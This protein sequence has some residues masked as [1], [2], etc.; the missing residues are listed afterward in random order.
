MFIA[1]FMAK[2]CHV[3]GKALPCSWQ[4]LVMFMARPPCHVHGKAFHRSLQRLPGGRGRLVEAFRSLGRP[5]G[6][7]EAFR[8]LGRPLKAPGKHCFG[9]MMRHACFST[10]LSQGS[11]R[12]SCGEAGNTKQDAQ[13]VD[14][15]RAWA[16]GDN[17]IGHSCPKAA[18]LWTTTAVQ[19]TTTSWD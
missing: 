6:A 3:H 11:R 1:M 13:S 16:H 19:L 9:K 7:R 4:G 5:R 2:P 18:A 14:S 12:C 15:K 8:S 10:T 17:A